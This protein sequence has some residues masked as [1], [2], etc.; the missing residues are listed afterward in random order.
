MLWIEKN[1]FPD[2]NAFMIDGAENLEYLIFGDTIMSYISERTGRRLGDTPKRFRVTNSPKL[3]HIQIGDQMFTDFTEFTI[4]NLP[5]LRLLQ[6]GS[7]NF[8]NAPLFSITSRN[9]HE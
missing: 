1:N 5:A 4:S 9:M 8:E 2:M 6:I 3:T 7:R